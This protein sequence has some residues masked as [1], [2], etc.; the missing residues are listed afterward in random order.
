MSDTG[1]VLDPR[2]QQLSNAANKAAAEKAARAAAAAEEEKK[3]KAAER[4][5]KQ[6]QEKRQARRDAR[7]E[8]W[9]N[10]FKIEYPQY[11][12]MFDEIDQAK[13]ADVFELFR[14]KADPDSGLTD[15]RFAQEFQGT[16]WYREIQASNMVA[17]INAQVGTVSWDAGAL[18]R[19][20][21]KA[22]G[23]GWKDE[24]LKQETYKEI[25]KKNELGQYVNPDSVNTVR[26]TANYLRY[27]NT[28]KQ[29]F[30]SL[31]EDK[32]VAALTGTATDEDIATG[33]RATAK[34]KYGH[35]A[36]AIDAGETLA[37]LSSDYKKTAASILERNESDIDMSSAD[38][39]K[40]LAF[41][42]GKGKRMMTT[43]EWARLLKTDNRYGWRNTQNAIETGR[44]VAKSIIQSFQRGF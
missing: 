11:S 42:D 13:Y 18:T 30:T 7:A 34:L 32:I 8:Q 3:K 26:N 9:E 12:W 43:G 14:R 4:R 5:R 28:A 19:F 22:V 31:G 35:L 29:Y 17:D 44:Q 41:D 10:Q 39:E 16:S 15:E 23:M 27:Q 2:E 21:N 25:F 36:A 33:L 37:D 6:Q 40:A 1:P 24:Q 38:F 20:V